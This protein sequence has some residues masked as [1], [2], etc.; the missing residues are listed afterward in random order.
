[1]ACAGPG[2][3]DGDATVPQGGAAYRWAAGRH[4]QH[5]DLRLLHELLRAWEATFMIQVVYYMARHV[6]VTTGGLAYIRLQGRRKDIVHMDA[7]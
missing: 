2:A 6:E 4:Y 7:I 5:R 3:L 1:M